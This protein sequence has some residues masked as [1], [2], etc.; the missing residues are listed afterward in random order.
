MVQHIRNLEQN[1]ECQQ[2]LRQHITEGH[3]KQLSNLLGE[4]LSPSDLEHLSD[5]TGNSLNNDAPRND[6]ISALIS[7]LLQSKKEAAILEMENQVHLVQKSNEN[8]A[9]QE[10]CDRLE[11]LNG[12][13]ERARMD[14]HSQAIK[15]AEKI[16]QL[17]DQNAADIINMRSE[18]INELKEQDRLYLD[19]FMLRTENYLREEGLKIENMTHMA[20]AVQKLDLDFQKRGAMIETVESENQTLKLK[21]SKTQKDLEEKE[22]KLKSIED[23]NSK[24]KQELAQS[25]EDLN[26]VRL[27]YQEKFS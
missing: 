11:S 9:L 25:R 24:I 13:L 4:D 14:I 27:E 8:K 1:F 15:D 18:K 3:A 12:Q 6:I 2:L 22:S 23:F 5:L 17:Q 26:Q 20:S 10:R 7:L 21:L 16:K 19:I